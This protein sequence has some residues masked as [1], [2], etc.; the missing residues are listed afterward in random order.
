MAGRNLMRTTKKKGVGGNKP[1]I[2]EV[3]WRIKT[4]NVN[5][6]VIP[7]NKREDYCTLCQEPLIVMRK[8]INKLAKKVIRLEQCN[9]HFHENCAL[10]YVKHNYSKE[11]Y[12]IPIYSGTDEPISEGQAGLHILNTPELLQAIMSGENEND[13]YD[14]MEEFEAVDM[15]DMKT[16]PNCNN[17]IIFP[18]DLHHEKSGDWDYFGYQVGM[19]AST[20]N[21]MVNYFKVVDPDATLRSG[22][23]IFFGHDLRQ[24]QQYAIEVVAET[25]KKNREVKKAKRAKK[26]AARPMTMMAMIGIALGR[27][28]NSGSQG[29]LPL[30]LPTGRE[31]KVL[32]HVNIRHTIFK[33]ENLPQTTRSGTSLR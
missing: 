9:C 23:S 6:T 27:Q 1:T 4:T 13:G 25:N 26:V 16:C 28:A 20:A 22:T 14:H 21:A 19:L 15:P 2:L 7:A 33:P 12:N 30:Q 17:N 10:R 3:M 8:N 29:S 5:L 11:T 18:R 24:A 32:E 31:G